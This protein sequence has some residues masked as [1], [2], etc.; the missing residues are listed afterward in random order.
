MNCCKKVKSLKI[1]SKTK[2]EHLKVSSG[3]YNNCPFC[4]EHDNFL[5]SDYDKDEILF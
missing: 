5:L 2:N 4:R 3:F 1:N